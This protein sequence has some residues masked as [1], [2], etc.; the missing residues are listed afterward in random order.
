MELSWDSFV[1][2]FKY[3]FIYNIQNILLA[4][5]VTCKLKGKA[6][7]HCRDGE[8]FLHVDSLNVA[9]DIKQAKMMVKNIYRNNKILG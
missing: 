7:T 2:E 4:D 3:I 6:S 9:V 8:K 1:R 5:D